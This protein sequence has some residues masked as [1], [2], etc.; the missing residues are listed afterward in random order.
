[1]TLTERTATLKDRCT[2]LENLSSTIDEAATF[3]TRFA[4]L[5]ESV[6]DMPACLANI[7]RLR[8]A[9]VSI[10]EVPDALHR[11]R[12]ALKK[13]Q[14]RFAQ[15]RTAASL[16]RGQDWNQ[17]LREL[18]ATIRAFDALAM[19]AW[20]RYVDNIFVGEAPDVVETRLARTDPNQ[21]ALRRY[22]QAYDGFSRAGLTLPE[23]MNDIEAVRQAAK[24]LAAIAADFDFDVPD[25]VKKF[26]DAL[27]QGGAPLSLLTEEVRTW[28][29]TQGQTNRYRVIAGGR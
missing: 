5:N 14:S 28:I 6:E 1:M 9:S 25:A 22:K 23:S 20:K 17:L 15:S 18:P 21:E 19:Q 29:T 11:A 8:D 24:N 2:R 16:T 7:R 10:G 27:P 26:L 4:E 3:S 13:I 12:S